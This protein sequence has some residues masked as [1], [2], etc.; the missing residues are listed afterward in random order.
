MGQ[1]LFPR[2]QLH[3]DMSQRRAY[4]SIRQQDV[5]KKVKSICYCDMM[6]FRWL[7]I[8]FGSRMLNVLSAKHPV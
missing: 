7:L 8:L 6:F 2:D 3:T 5:D 1:I 4:Q